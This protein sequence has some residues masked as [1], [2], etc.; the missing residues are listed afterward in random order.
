MSTSGEETLAK[1]P[2]PLRKALDDYVNEKHSDCLITVTA[3]K[4]EPK[5]FAL[6]ELGRKLMPLEQLVND[7]TLM[8]QGTSIHNWMEKNLLPHIVKAEGK[9]QETLWL[10]EKELRMKVAMDPTKQPGD[11]TP[12][13]E[14]G[15]TL[16]LY[17]LANRHLYDFKLMNNFKLGKAA[18]DY[19]LQLNAYRVMLRASGFPEPEKLSLVEISRDFS[20]PAKGGRSQNDF[21]WTI[22]DIPVDQ[23]ITESVLAQLA[24]DRVRA[25]LQLREA[26]KN[27]KPTPAL[28][29]RAAEGLGDQLPPCPG[30]YVS[31]W[32]TLPGGVGRKCMYCAA[33]ICCNQMKGGA[34]VGAEHMA[35]K[36]KRTRKTK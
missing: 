26:W 11:G 4:M 20:D 23:D 13:F 31:E 24:R 33:R 16:D 8:L 6:S 9:G 19:S 22:E 32:G 34:G 2:E 7:S 35:A 15:G 12:F 25:K 28:R 10:L 1:M 5:A 27:M 36:P 3:L 30:E 18:A 21:P 29:L 17:D 14:L